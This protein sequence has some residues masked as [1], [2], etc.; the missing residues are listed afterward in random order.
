MSGRDSVFGTYVPTGSLVERLPAAATYGVVLALTVPALLVRQWWVTA[1]A[2]AVVVVVLLAGRLGWRGLR[3][4]WGLVVLVVLMGAYH[5]LVGTWLDGVVLAGNVVLAVLA[6]RLLTMTKPVP[7]LLD[8]LVA[9]ARPVRWV[10]LSAERFGLAVAVML[11][12]IPHLVGAFGEVRDAARARGLER[13]PMAHVTPVV[14]RAVAYAQAT[15][16]ALI[17]RGL[18][19]DD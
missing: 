2:L 15:G 16:D 9:A 6:S 13:N 4:P 8:A 12:S 19:E 5:V 10:G 1:V 14:V 17:A 3:L 18:G 7:V 11:R